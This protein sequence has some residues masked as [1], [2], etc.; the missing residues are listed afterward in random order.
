MG[1]SP[2]TM[3]GGGDEIEKLPQSCEQLF[4]ALVDAVQPSSSKESVSNAEDLV[5][6]DLDTAILVRDYLNKDKER[7]IQVEGGESSGHRLRSRVLDVLRPMIAREV[8]H[9]TIREIEKGKGA[10]G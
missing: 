8:A 4:E 3:G 2:Q 9:R 5:K 6:A 10:G 7:I 1:R